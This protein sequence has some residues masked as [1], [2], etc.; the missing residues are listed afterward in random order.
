MNEDKPTYM[1]IKICWKELPI[2]ELEF[3]KV[4]FENKNYLDVCERLFQAIH[5]SKIGDVCQV[6][7]YFNPLNEV[8]GL[9]SEEEIIQKI[10][11]I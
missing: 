1:E 5:E 3:I 2:K 8:E 4:T 9:L 7:Y 11:N 10:N 6:S